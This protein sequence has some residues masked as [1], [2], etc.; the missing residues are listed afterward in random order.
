MFTQ[1]GSWNAKHTPTRHTGGFVQYIHL[2]VKEKMSPFWVGWVS[3]THIWTAM[4]SSTILWKTFSPLF[5]PSSTLM[6]LRST[7]RHRH[8]GK[9]KKIP[10]IMAKAQ[11]DSL[12]TEIQMQT[13]SSG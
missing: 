3:K 7:E 1:P 6:K 8:G 12:F 5:P 9:F 11:G 10:M 2:I 4:E 13:R